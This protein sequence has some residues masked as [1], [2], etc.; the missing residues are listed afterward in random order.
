MLVMKF[1]VQSILL[2]LFFALLAIAQDTPQ[3]IQD[4]V[5]SRNYIS[6]INELRNLEKSDKKTFVGNNYDY[7]LARMAEKT[8]RCGTCDGE[9]S[10]GCKK[11]L[12]FERVR[13][14]APLPDRP[15]ERKSYF[16]KSLSS[17][18]DF[19]GLSF[20]AAGCRSKASCPQ[21]F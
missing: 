17:A 15:F 7:L 8:G 3:R 4:A 20:I 9:I 1:F 16:R 10:D 12:S 13:L 19:D 2:I 21:L 5:A 11:E 18:I 14:L 6:A